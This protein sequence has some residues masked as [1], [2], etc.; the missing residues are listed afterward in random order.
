MNRLII[1]DFNRTLYNPD[2]QA[3]LPG[4][5]ALLTYAHSKDYV[6][7]LLSK[8]SPTR[9]Q[10]VDEL[11]IASFFAE[12]RFVEHKTAELL[13]D[14]VHRHNGD[15]AASYVV[16]DRSQS[17]LMCGHQAG[18]R[19]IWLRI[20][21]FASELPPAGHEPTHIVTSLD[22]IPSLLV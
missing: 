21:K 15:K 10:L 12:M 14:I 18:L 22:Q 20:G 3:L 6:L 8:A 4:A 19:T 17:E 13:E 2:T 11:G 1:F 9:H 7:V 16:G 5:S